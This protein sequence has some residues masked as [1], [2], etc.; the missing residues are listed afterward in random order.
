MVIAIMPPS[1]LEATVLTQPQGATE[2]IPDTLSLTR[3]QMS[4]HTCSQIQ[5]IS[6]SGA[7]H[8]MKTHRLNIQGD[9]QS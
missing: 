4:T 2:D 9:I 8:N 3:E 1:L 5:L 6:S 7:E